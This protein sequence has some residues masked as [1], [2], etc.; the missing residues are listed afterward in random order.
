MVR[1]VKTDWH[2]VLGSGFGAALDAIQSE[3][4]Q[5]DEI[6]F[7]KISE[8]KTTTVQDHAGVYRYFRHTPTGITVNFQT[9][10]LHGFEG[11]E[12]RD[13]VKTVM[14]PRLAGT[15]K[16]ILTNASGGLKKEMK[17][18][19]ACVIT[20]HVNLTGKNPLVGENP[21]RTDGSEIGPRFPDMGN[22]YNKPWQEGLTRELKKTN[23]GVH[24]GTYIG[25]L[26]PSF[27]THAEIRLFA[28]WG[29]AAV[30]MSTVWE[31]IALKHS[32]A[33]LA[34]VSLVSN[35]GAG[36]SEESLD[37]N[38]I[39]KTCRGSAAA[40]LNSICNFIIQKP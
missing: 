40:I 37:H 12:P 7:A 4:Q 31:A 36:L 16:F 1:L 11:H 6:P 19:D 20:D 21:K 27:E 23:L 10:R 26:G 32:G 22:L 13:V 2:V 35:L 30:G 25:I 18:G 34:G 15:E 5:T 3:W 8:L 29:M 39:V 14:L 33:T 28:Q 17:S 24:A 38:E 9:G